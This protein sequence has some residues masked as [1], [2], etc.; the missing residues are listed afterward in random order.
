MGTHKG[1]PDVVFGFEPLNLALPRSRHLGEASVMGRPCDAFVFTQDKPEP[2]HDLVM[3]LD[4]ETG[5]PLEVR[6]YR[7][8]DDLKAGRPAYA[9]KAGS[10]KTFQGHP[11]VNSS[12]L[13]R[14]SEADSSINH[15]SDFNV[16]SVEFDKD[17]A[18]SEFFPVIPPG[19]EV[20]DTIAGKI[21][22]WP[23]AGGKTKTRPTLAPTTVTST[24]DP[25]APPSEPFLPGR[26]PPRASSSVESASPCSP[27]ARCSGGEAPDSPRAGATKATRCIR[28]A[29]VGRPTKIFQAP[30][31][32]RPAGRPPGPRCRERFGSPGRFA[33]HFV[34]SKCFRCS[35]ERSR[36]LS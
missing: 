4:R 13:E 16:Q 19:T 20:M 27:P 35:R 7:T 30:L 11:V 18:A 1:C 23:G 12:R 36:W 29:G 5:V 22:I 31:A 10:L 17:H 26:E 6:G 32:V 33:A 14:Y 25:A 28:L 2:I 9:W 21:V 34:G 3:V 15:T 24:Q 8:P